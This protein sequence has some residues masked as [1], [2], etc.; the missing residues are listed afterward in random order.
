ML[1]VSQFSQHAKV[2][3]ALYKLGKIQLMKGNRERSKYYLDRV[4]SEYSDSNKSV[5]KLAQDFIFKNNL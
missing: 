4:I 1:L 2:P 3:D 5:V